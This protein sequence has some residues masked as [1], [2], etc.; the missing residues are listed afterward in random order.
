[1]AAWLPEKAAKKRQEKAI[2]EQL[3]HPH[4]NPDFY[5]AYYN[6]DALM[7]PVIKALDDSLYHDLVEG[8]LQVL[9]RFGDR[10]AMAHGIELR[11]P[12][13]SPHLV[14][15]AFSLQPEKKIN[16]GYTKWLL[17][18]AYKKELSKE[19]VWRKGKIGFEPPQIHWMNQPNMQDLMMESRRSL[20]QQRILLPTVLD[21]PLQP[22][23]AHAP[24]GFDW[25][26]LC[27]A[28]LLKV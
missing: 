12:Y 7:Q 22:T 24:N 16:Q 15:F 17:R 8:P 28:N 20:V 21:E 13:L 27:A 10:N 2:Q 1:V 26:Y 23:E 9:L 6:D 19:I 14:S 3:N 11:L 25:R 4:L 5:A 18:E